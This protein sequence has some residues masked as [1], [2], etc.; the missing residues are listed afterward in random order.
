MGTDAL[1]HRGLLSLTAEGHGKGEK[2]QGPTGLD[3]DLAHLA[4]TGVGAPV[5]ENH[6]SGSC[7]HMN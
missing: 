6:L 5:D 2:E 4:A 3:L 1:A 7:H